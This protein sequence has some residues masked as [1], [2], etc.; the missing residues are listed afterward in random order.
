[1][2][3]QF[4]DVVFTRVAGVSALDGSG[5][6]LTV[7]ANRQ[8]FPAAASNGE[9]YL[10]VWEDTRATGSSIQA[11]R[12]SAAGAWLDGASVRLGGVKFPQSYPSAAWNGSA[13]QVVWT[14][15]QEGVLTAR[16]DADGASLDAEP[17]LLDPTAATIAR[18]GCGGGVCLVPFVRPDGHEWL[19]RLGQDGHPVDGAAIDLG[20]A[21]NGDPRATVAYHDGVFAVTWTPTDPPAY[22][23]LAVTRLTTDGTILD[24]EPVRLADSGQGATVV[25]TDVDFLVAWS[26][27][28]GPP[29]D[30]Y[31]VGFAVLGH[32][33]GVLAQGTFGPT[34]GN[35]LATAPVFSG[36]DVFL[37]WQENDGSA[38]RILL[39]R[40]HASGVVL[41]AA[42]FP[43][44]EVWPVS[45][46]ATAS[47]GHGDALVV[48]DEIDR[49]PD[50]AATRLRLR[51]LHEPGGGP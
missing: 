27:L 39:R 4:G 34:S 25:A 8:W 45:A 44:A 20:E 48:W 51:L 30:D 37:P 23:A 7:S 6:L 36:Q 19:W 32:G 42:P 5:V 41:D 26:A 46:F 21:G 40:V 43:V 29:T 14:S 38:G 47:T 50:I 17:V 16:L 1:V 33:G 18:V 11:A 10:V 12:L 28:S 22:G 13:Y 49:S 15:P 2:G 35:Q 31:D 9:D 24:T 3:A